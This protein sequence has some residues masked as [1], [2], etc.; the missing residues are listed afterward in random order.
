MSDREYRAT[1]VD[2]H[3][4]SRLAL[5]GS[6][7][8]L[9]ALAWLAILG[10]WSAIGMGIAATIAMPLLF[11]IANI[12]SAGLMSVFGYLIERGFRSLAL[13]SGFSASL[14][15]SLL[16]MGWCSIVFFHVT[17]VSCQEDL[18]PLLLWGYGVAV[19]PLGFMAK[20][21][22]GNRLTSAFLVIAHLLYALLVASFAME[23][24][25]QVALVLV[26]VSAL[27][28]PLFGLFAGIAT[29]SRKAGGAMIAH[30]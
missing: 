28:L 14:F 25:A 17:E 12:P 13:A 21:D 2:Y 11:R 27:I 7:A 18:L 26:L 22:A 16:V 6:V 29:L 20:F 30:E 8:W 5:A 19:V 4:D 15:N 10:Q 1:R 3:A 9:V 23:M 24:P